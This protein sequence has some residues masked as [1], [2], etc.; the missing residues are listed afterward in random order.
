[1]TEEPPR[2]RQLPSTP[3][4][5]LLD[6]VLER[7][8]AVSGDLIIALAGID[9]LRLDLRLLLAPIERSETR[10]GAPDGF[11][12]GAGGRAPRGIERGLEPPQGRP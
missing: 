8:A 3:L 11:A 9:L 12:G 10:G 2:S 4:V 7:G 1:M 5:D 6:R